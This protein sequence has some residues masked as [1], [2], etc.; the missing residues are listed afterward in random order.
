[1]TQK[2]KQPKQKFSAPNSVS[3][4]P[5]LPGEKFM[6]PGPGWIFSSLTITGT[7]AR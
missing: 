3:T 5:G 6:I 2:N 4:K 7:R 1:M